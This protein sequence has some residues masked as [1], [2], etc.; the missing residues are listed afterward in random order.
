MA[1]L[2]IPGQTVEGLLGN[3]APRFRREVARI[4]EDSFRARGMRRVT[5]AE[6]QRR[7][8]FCAKTA[9]ELRRRLKWPTERIVDQLPAALKAFIDGVSWEPDTRASWASTDS[10][11]TKDN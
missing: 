9:G 2:W 6:I 11:W 5:K 4:L 10:T 8:D 7:V 3:D 1:D